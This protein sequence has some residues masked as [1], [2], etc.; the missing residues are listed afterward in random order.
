MSI[1]IKDEKGRLT[2]SDSVVAEL[3]NIS[4]TISELD[5]KEQSIRN[6]I[7]SEMIAN[8]IEKCISSGMTFTQIIPKAKET[9][10]TE[11]FLMNE[12]EDV[13][14]C[15]TTYDETCDFDIEKFKSENPSLY[16]KYLKKT[17]IP[18]VDTNKMKKVLEPMYEKYCTR[19]ESSK[20]IS[21]RITEKKGA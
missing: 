2:I 9:F 7:L 18:I 21:L 1:I 16:D 6:D 3:K 15:F 8:N 10:D 5:R 12:S 19:V 13:V 20:P 14:N 17:I 11:K 4:D